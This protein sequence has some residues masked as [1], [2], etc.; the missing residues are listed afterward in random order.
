MSDAPECTVRALVIGC[1]LGALLVCV[2]VYMGLKTGFNESGNITA[3]LLGFVLLRLIAQPSRLENNIVQTTATSAAAMCF[4]T[5]VGGIIP[6]LDLGGHRLPVWWFAPWGIAL[7]FVGIALGGWFRESLLFAERLPFPTGIATAEVI[8]TLHRSGERIGARVRALLA[9][10]TVAGLITWFRDGRPAVIPDMLLLHGRIR[11]VDTSALLL[12]AAVSPMLLAAGA[13][14]GL[15]LGASVLVGALTAWAGLAPAL[16]RHGI[17]AGADYAALVGWLLWPAAALMLSSSLVELAL[18]WRRFTKL[19]VASS[20][21]PRSGLGW[22]A[23]GGALVAILIGWRALHVAPW[24]TLLALLFA[25]VLSN[26]A[27][28]A[29]GETDVN[30]VGPMGQLT[31]LAYGAATRDAVSN[32]AAA[33]VVTGVGMQMA[34]SIWSYKAGSLLGATP[35]RQLWAQLL[36]AAFGAI[37]AVPAYVVIVRAFGLGSNA[38]PA[39]G[40]LA[41]KAVA[42][43]ATGGVAALPPYAAVVSLVAFALG[44]LLTLL[45][46]LR[47]LRFVPSPAAMGIGMLVPASYGV[48]L[49][50]G[51]AA[52]AIVARRWRAWAEALLQ[53]LAAGAIAGEALVGLLVATLRVVGVLH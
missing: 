14:V 19:R 28:R 47:K 34:T 2:N 30:P 4:A 13:L 8:Q 6:A 37:V 39:P 29:A 38:L 22:L 45:Q 20:A 5:G 31:Q 17:V 35:R 49:F 9:G 52:S 32:I 46:R 12:G 33:G 48:T 53:S 36:G 3:S 51:A 27:T 7:A 16:V 18:D 24:W 44:A 23:V 10:S 50:L 1:A 43:G 26:V 40:A 41:F 42:E 11:G 15:H 21:G 25:I